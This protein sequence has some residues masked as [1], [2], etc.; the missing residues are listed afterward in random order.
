MT[1]RELVND[2]GNLMIISSELVNSVFSP[3]RLRALRV[4]P[5]LDRYTDT[6]YLH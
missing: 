3:P 2:L 6:I 5:P 4:K 1:F